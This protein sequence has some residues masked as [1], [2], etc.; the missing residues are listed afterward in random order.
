MSFLHCQHFSCDPCCAHTRI[1]TRVIQLPHCTLYLVKTTSAASP[2]RRPQA[3]AKHPKKNPYCRA[4]CI[5]FSCIYTLHGADSICRAPMLSNTSNAHST[6]WV[7]Y[8]SL[9]THPRD[10]QGTGN[11]NEGGTG[12]E[13]MEGKAYV[14]GNHK[15]LEESNRI[16]IRF[17]KRSLLLP[18]MMNC[19]LVRF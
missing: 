1:H 14:N 4:F 19:L 15:Q 11:T 12:T 16:W 2:P 6:S 3:F 17:G 13:Y 7:A 9:T 5:W 18:G 10:Y 8:D